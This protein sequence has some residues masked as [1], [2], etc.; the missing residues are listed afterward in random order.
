MLIMFRWVEGVYVGVY[1]GAG[2]AVSIINKILSSN[3]MNTVLFFFFFFLSFWFVL[4]VFLFLGPHPWHMEVRRLGVQLELQL[5]AYTTATATQDPS[6]DCD[7]HHSSRQCQIFNPLSE[8]RDRTPVFRDASLVSYCWVTAG[9]S[10]LPFF[11][12]PT[13]NYSP[14]LTC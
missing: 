3:R 5:L 4:F 12:P 8:V 10:T 7:L 13:V 14:L 2:N 1:V 6:H 11:S 9:T